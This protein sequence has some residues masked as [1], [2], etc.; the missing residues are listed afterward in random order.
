MCTKV[1]E[2]SRASG[3]NSLIPG[4]SQKLQASNIEQMQKVVNNVTLMLGERDDEIEAL[5][6]MNRDLATQMMEFTLSNR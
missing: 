1:Q 3:F 5:K 2:N 6:L 4:A